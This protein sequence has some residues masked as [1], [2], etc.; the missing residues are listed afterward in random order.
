MTECIGTTEAAKM[1]GITKARICQLCKAKELKATFVSG[2][3]L[4]D[5]ADI[6]TFAYQRSKHK[7]KDINSL[8]I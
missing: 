7:G 6:M 2:V 4:I 8:G 3:W 1:L 5:K